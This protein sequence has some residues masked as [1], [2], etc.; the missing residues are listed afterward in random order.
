M[1][2]FWFREFFSAFCSSYFWTFCASKNV[3]EMLFRDR[4]RLLN[5]IFTRLSSDY[6]G[7][8]LWCFKKG[9]PRPLFNLFNWAIPGHFFFIVVFSMQFIYL[10]QLIVNVINDYWI[11]ITNL[12]CLKPIPWTKFSITALPWNKALSMDVDVGSCLTNFNQLE[13]IILV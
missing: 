1:T 8:P 9:Q 11:R 4:A 6:L 3:I 5:N 2:M 12:C 10:K 7:R 13:C